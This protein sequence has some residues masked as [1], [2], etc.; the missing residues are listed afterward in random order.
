MA[1]ESID[2]RSDANSSINPKEDIMYRR[3]RIALMGL[4]EE[5]A[6][7]LPSILSTAMDE[8]KNAPNIGVRYS[9]LCA[10]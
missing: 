7:D 10:S 5:L 1:V 4:I 9:H 2:G 8:N 3:N 6:S